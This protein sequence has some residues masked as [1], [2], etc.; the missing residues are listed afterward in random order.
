[1]KTTTK[2]RLFT[3]FNQKLEKEESRELVKEIKPYDTG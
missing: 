2:I 1:M 3:L